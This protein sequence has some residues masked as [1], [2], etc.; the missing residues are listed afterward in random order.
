ME[1]A[2][3]KSPADIL[4]D[5]VWELARTIVEARKQ[6][7]ALRPT[8][9]KDRNVSAALM[10][11]DEIVKATEEASNTI[12]GAAEQMSDTDPS[13]ASY[14]EMVQQNCTR[15]FEACAFQDL[16]GQRISK[17]MKTLEMVDD[18]LSALQELLGP[19]FE[20]PEDDSDEPQGDAALLNGP[21]LG[22]EAISQDDIDA[23]FD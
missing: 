23:L 4:Y 16:T 20:E 17:V 12:M 22:D 14:A 1:P 10:E 18:H 21:A 7:G 11:M 19:E 5:E 15:I 13:D 6:I 3:R 2:V 8:K 9:L